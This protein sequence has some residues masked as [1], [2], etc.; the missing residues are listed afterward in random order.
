MAGALRATP[1]RGW[2]VQGQMIAGAS[3]GGALF[4]AAAIPGGWLSGAMVALA[5][6]AAFG[7]AAPL[8]SALRQV[9][10]VASGAAIGSAVT[11]EMLHGVGRYPASLIIMTAAVA[12]ITAIG[13]FMLRRLSGF[14]RETA[15]FAAVP[16]ALSYVFAVAAQTGADMPRIAIV[17]VLRVFFLMAVLPLAVVE[18]GVPLAPRAAGPEQAWW[19]MAVIFGLGY[20]CGAA[21]ERRG[22]AGGMLFG[23]MI[24]SGLMHVGGLAPGRLSPFVAIA[25]QILVG[26]WSGSRFAG[27]DWR[28]LGRLALVSL[29]AFALTMGVAALFALLAAQTLALP[30]PATLLAFAPGG[31]EAMTLLAF[32][33]GIDPLYVGVHHLVRFVLISLSLPLVS[34]LWLGKSA[35]E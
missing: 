13:A 34:R 33:L 2:L 9:A 4:A 15:F 24:A 28:L 17:Q 3:L 1:P 32:A 30:F 14:D 21:L 35:K 26:A 6:M 19:M 12:A 5:V 20:A 8:H 16:G 23:A 25:G 29:G 22:M 7:Q 11:P 31:L 18:A 10:M 27:F